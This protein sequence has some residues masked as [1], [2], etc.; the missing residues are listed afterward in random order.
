MICSV[1]ISLGPGRLKYA[2]PSLQNTRPF[3]TALNVCNLAMKSANECAGRRARAGRLA[4]LP[5]HTEYI[6]QAGRVVGSHEWGGRQTCGHGTHHSFVDSA[7]PT[8]GL[9]EHQVGCKAGQ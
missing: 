8:E 3:R 4:D 2:D 1:S 6:L 7:D 5:H 9:R